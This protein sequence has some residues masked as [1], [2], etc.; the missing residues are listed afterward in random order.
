MLD[1][2]CIADAD[3]SLALMRMVASEDAMPAH[4]VEYAQACWQRPSVRRFLSYL[5]TQRL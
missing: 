4:L 2:W 1:S 5:P 3:L